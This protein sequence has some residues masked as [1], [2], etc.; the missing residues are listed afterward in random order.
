[1]RNDLISIDQLL[2]KGYT[3]MMEVQTMRVIDCKDRLIVKAILS[4]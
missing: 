3:M 4:K 1:M 2:Q